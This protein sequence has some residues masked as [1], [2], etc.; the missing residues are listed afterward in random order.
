[1]PVISLGWIA[2]VMGILIAVSR[3][4]LLLDPKKSRT[5]IHKAFEVKIGPR[6][7]GVFL[8]VMGLATMKTVMQ[9]QHPLEILMMIFGVLW[10][11]VGILLV[12]RP[13]IV[14]TFIEKVCAQTDVVF[15]VVNLFILL[16][17]LGLIYLGVA[18]YGL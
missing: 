11:L 14:G 4:P 5:V 6:L 13:L 2:L 8:L 3:L 17:G 15:R 7:V 9:T 16:I 18:I 10:L 12:V 1:M